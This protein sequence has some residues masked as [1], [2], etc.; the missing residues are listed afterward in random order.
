MNGLVGSGDGIKQLASTV[1]NLT[2]VNLSNLGNLGNLNL[3]TALDL[4]AL[5]LDGT[6]SANANTGKSS[7]GN[8]VGDLVNGLL[9]LLG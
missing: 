3:S 8:L 2:T 4:K 7:S 1:G 6:V 9:N 5:G